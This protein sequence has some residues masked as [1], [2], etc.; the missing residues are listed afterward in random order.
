MQ[1]NIKKLSASILLFFL[2][3]IVVS[4][5]TFERYTPT[6]ALC[7][8]ACT[9]VPLLIWILPP[10]TA[11]AHRTDMPPASGWPDLVPALVLLLGFALLLPSG[12]PI[13]F[14]RPFWLFLLVGVIAPIC[15]ELFFRSMFFTGLAGFDV[16]MIVLLSATFFA[17]QHS[18]FGALYALFAGLIFALAMSEGYGLLWCMAL[19]SATNL[20]TLGLAW[21]WTRGQ[22]VLYFC[23]LSALFVAGAGIGILR[24]CHGAYRLKA[25]VYPTED[26]KPLPFSSPFFIG[27]IVVDILFL[28]IIIGK[29]IL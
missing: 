18:G 6:H 23:C 28:C 11:L 17:I 29:E 5:I 13:S 3:Q 8:L 16:R 22:T 19:H 27:V 9:L 2:L 20:T 10:R 15:E 1:T 24:A 26:G 4:C 7:A 14:A 21:L 12:A 25:H